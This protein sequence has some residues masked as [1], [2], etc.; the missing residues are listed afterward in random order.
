VPVHFVGCERG[1]HFYAMQYI[2]GRTLAATIRELR[3][4][5]PV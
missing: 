5:W 1:V 3:Q 2:E 4:H